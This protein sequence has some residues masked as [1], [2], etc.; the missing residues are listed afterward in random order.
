MTTVKI[1]LRAFTWADLPTVV[2]LVNRSEAVDKVE[3]G[4][5]E[6]ELG[7][8][9][10]LPGVEAETNTFLALVDG[11]AVGY[12]RLHLGEGDQ[13]G[14]FSK[15]RAYG[16]V[17][18]EWRRQGVGTRIMAELE[19]RAR[20]RL[21]EISTATV[22]LQAV[23]D[24]RQA[25]AAALYRS[26]GMEP[27]RY[28][29]IMVYDDPQ[30]PSAPDYPPG[31]RARPFV[32]NQDEETVWRVANTAFRDHWGHVEESLD[33]W[34]AWFETDYCSPELIFLT[35]ITSPPTASRRLIAW[36]IRQPATIVTSSAR[37]KP[38]PKAPRLWSVTQSAKAVP[39]HRRRRSATRTP[40]SR[41]ALHPAPSNWTA[42]RGSRM[43]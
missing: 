43:P 24:R 25:G 28:F 26:R 40:L 23:A 16:T 7:T 11:E 1:T 12:G 8:L 41:I 31:Y 33:E 37:R 32:R 9:W 18:P 30:M 21:D 3:R 27:V 36:S 6:E 20:A 17:V 42:T 34:L 2:D 29:L 38:R 14:S 5:S 22:Y 4:T 19:R 15:V 39:R 13:R 10:R 35:A